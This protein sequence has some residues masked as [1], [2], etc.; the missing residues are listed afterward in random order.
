MADLNLLRKIQEFS[1]R[2]P[3]HPAI[4]FHDEVTTYEDLASRVAAIS[5]HFLAAGIYVGS[6]V[7]I[8]LRRSPDM[9][10]AILAVLN[11][12]AAFV[13]LPLDSPKARN[14]LVAELADLNLL[15]VD[16]ELHGSDFPARNHMRLNEISFA[17]NPI[18]PVAAFDEQELAYIIF[19]SGS[20]GQPKGVMVRRCNLDYFLD[21]IDQVVDFCRWN[22]ILAATTFGFD[23]SVLELLLPLANGGTLILADDHQSRSSDALIRLAEGRE[24]CLIQATPTMWRMIVSSG[25][26]PDCD[27]GAICG[28]EVLPTQLARELFDRSKAAW[29]LYGPTETTI[30]SFYHC[31]S[32]ADFADPGKAV[33]IG[34]PLPGTSYAIEKA[35]GELGDGELRIDG[36]GVSGGYFRRPDLNQGK[37]T[38]ASEYGPFD[39][40][41]TGDLVVERNDGRLI[42]VGRKDRQVKLN[43]FRIEPGEIERA[44]DRLPFVEQ[45]AVKLT[46]TRSSEK[47]LTAFI[48]APQLEERVESWGAVWDA[49]YDLHGQTSIAEG[50]GYTSTFT[51]KPIGETQIKAWAQATA[52]RV[53][54][55][56]P[57]S[58]L[59]IGCGVGLLGERLLREGLVKYQGCDL[60]SAA[61]AAA[62]K[63]LAQQF[64][65]SPRWQLSCVPANEIR[66]AVSGPFDLVLLNSVVQY[67]PDEDYLAAVLQQAI[68]LCRHGG[69]IVVGDI[70]AASM[71]PVMARIAAEASASDGSADADVEQRIKTI[72]RGELWLDPADF[73][74]IT[75]SQRR[76]A[77]TD[78]DLRLGESDD[79][80]TR[81][82]YDAVLH[83]DSDERTACHVAAVYDF[84]KDVPKAGDLSEW[85][86]T[87][88][89]AFIL[90]QIPN[91]R[92]LGKMGQRRHDAIA[93]VERDE[94]QVLPLTP[95]SDLTLEDFR[96]WGTAKRRAV[97]IM[98]SEPITKGSVDLC[99][100]PLNSFSSLFERSHLSRILGHQMPQSVSGST[101]R[102][103]DSK[104]RKLLAEI[105]PHY[106][107]PSQFVYLSKMPLTY[108]G[109]VDYKALQTVDLPQF[110][111][112]KEI[113]LPDGSKRDRIAAMWSAL[114]SIDEPP[115][116]LSFFLAGGSS[117]LTVELARRLSNAY[118]VDV[119]V[120]DLFVHT[121]ITDQAE[122]VE[123]LLSNR[124]TER[125]ER[126]NNK[127]I[128]AAIRRHNAALARRSGRVSLRE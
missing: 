54:G 85:L 31:L 33:P 84:E 97:R 22:R 6:R 96:R 83:L 58:V 113:E 13:P 12:G 37:F 124:P 44:L 42:Y 56:S 60:S 61:V 65:Q 98:W 94:A 62:Q 122:H 116:D 50:T 55:F 78:L 110:A 112:E 117:I 118:G 66:T 51:G 36:P 17:G 16:D 29:N 52:D 76:V 24:R 45:S 125:T 9:V 121:T 107:I 119:S 4:E 67:F 15:I 40:F 90:R 128:D 53:L 100:T 18:L 91:P 104:V 10:A 86:K 46:E 11:V 2:T 48:V 59:D 38:S 21:A 79:E 57:G 8:H 111:Q 19:T 123:R 127:I 27:V 73:T 68:A 102:Q 47:C 87:A 43:G 114:L 80:M 39:R 26:I 120:V 126:A 23:I 115:L 30:W 35:D 74:R 71:K 92:V 105:L 106:M 75:Q 70:P 7:G 25:W 81:F 95:T 20:T 3:D 88:P 63:R 72:G 64:G 41:M 5:K 89:D 32:E 108:N 28:G 1:W 103:R 34:Y 93:S 14:R 77:A 69:K 49:A 99:V 101:K 109:K 82:R